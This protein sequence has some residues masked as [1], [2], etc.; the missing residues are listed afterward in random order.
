MYFRPV[1]GHLNLALTK[2]GEEGRHGTLQ[3]AEEVLAYQCAHAG[4]CP[5]ILKDELSTDSGIGGGNKEEAPRYARRQFLQLFQERGEHIQH[6]LAIDADLTFDTTFQLFAACC[7]TEYE[8]KS[9]S[10]AFTQ[11]VLMCLSR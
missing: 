4:G 6:M 7:S 2:S 10:R 9:F 3:W 11:F 1:V 8:D 5:W